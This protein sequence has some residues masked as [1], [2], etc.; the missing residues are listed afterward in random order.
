MIYSCPH[1]NAKFKAEGPGFFVCPS[2][3]QKVKVGAPLAGTAWDVESQGKWVEAMVSTIKEAITE[4]VR[5]FESMAGGKGW[6]RPLIFAMVIS[7][8][9]FMISAAYQMGFQTIASSLDLADPAESLAF[10]SV[11]PISA[12]ALVMFAA[13][14]VPTGTTIG[15][16]VQAGIYHLCLMILGAAKKGFQDT[17]RVACYSM[18]PQVFQI[19]PLLGGLIAWGWQAVLSIIGIKVVHETSYGKSTVAVF[20]PMILCCGFIA[21][22]GAAVAGWIFAALISKSL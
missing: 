13:F 2:C 1:C 3:S 6:I 5:F 21:L 10:L 22:I 16:L 20:L 9:V 11:Y 14:A 18:A 17:F 7:M 8:L 15:L 4:P 19:V 12:G